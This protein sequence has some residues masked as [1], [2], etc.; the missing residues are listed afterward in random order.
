MIKF[1]YSTTGEYDI[2]SLPNVSESILIDA[3][4]NK[5]VVN[6]L[7]EYYFSKLSDLCSSTN[8]NPS[9]GLSQKGGYDM[10]SV[11]Q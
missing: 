3:S 10:F 8:Q 4:N 7:D 2:T 9:I 1:F 11:I 5:M 6:G